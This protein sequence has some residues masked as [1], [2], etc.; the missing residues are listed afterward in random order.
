M[1]RAQ[2]ATLVFLSKRYPGVYKGLVKPWS[3]LMVHLFTGKLATNNILTE[4]T[5][6]TEKIY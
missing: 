3:G 1:C 2:L 6:R 5:E 4:K